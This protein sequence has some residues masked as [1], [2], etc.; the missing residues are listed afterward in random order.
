VLVLSGKR[1]RSR[2]DLRGLPKGTVRVKVAATTSR[3]AKLTDTRTY[4]TC[5]PRR[6]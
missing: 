5:V 3:G 4:H 2:V 1:L 6:G